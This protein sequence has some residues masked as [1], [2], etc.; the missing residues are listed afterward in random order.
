MQEQRRIFKVLG[1]APVCSSSYSQ[2]QIT[3]YRSGKT[4]KE[5]ERKERTVKA[6]RE[7]VSK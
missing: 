5:E 2:S 6:E 1:T 3:S 7:I 4:M